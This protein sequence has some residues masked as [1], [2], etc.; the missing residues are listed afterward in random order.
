MYLPYINSCMQVS[1]QKSL[2]QKEIKPR[3]INGSDWNHQGGS[4]PDKA[5]VSKYVLPGKIYSCAHLCCTREAGTQWI[6]AQ[7]APVWNPV[8]QSHV[9][10]HSPPQLSHFRFSLL[11]ALQWDGPGWTTPRR[12]A[13]SQIRDQR[14][15]DDMSV[16]CHLFSHQYYFIYLIHCYYL[17]RLLTNRKSGIKLLHALTHVSLAV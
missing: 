7:P 3:T 5:C 8:E 11:A 10:T 17:F 9:P 12:S 4:V 16:Y 15:L 2:G 6:C 1:E 14:M 13:N